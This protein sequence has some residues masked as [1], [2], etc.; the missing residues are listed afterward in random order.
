MAGGV[1]PQRRLRVL[2]QPAPVPLP[3]PCAARRGEQRRRRGALLRHLPQGGRSRTARDGGEGPGRTRSARSGTTTSSRGRVASSTPA[4]APKRSGRTSL[5]LSHH[6]VVRGLKRHQ[7]AGGTR[8]DFQVPYSHQ[9]LLQL[10]LGAAAVPAGIGLLAA[11][12]WSVSSSRCKTPCAQRARREDSP[13]R[14]RAA[15]RRRTRRLGR[16]YP[17]GEACAHRL[18]PCR[19]LRRRRAT[20]FVVAEGRI[21][22][23]DLPMSFLA[24]RA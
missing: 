7:A 2:L 19:D 4:T 22:R 13:G 15:R 11:C 3:L 8:A 21:E 9:R 6:R 24:Q 10:L 23:G 18:D 5:R 1:G 16:R 20:G 14:R 12:S 17:L